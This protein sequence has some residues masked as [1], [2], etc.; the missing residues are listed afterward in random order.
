MLEPLLDEAEKRKLF[1]VCSV[2]PIECFYSP[3]EIRA[4]IKEGKHWIE[5]KTWVLRD[6]QIKIF[7]LER[8]ISQLRLELRD[9]HQEFVD[10]KI[11]EFQTNIQ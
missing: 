6:P 1:L 11:S 3:R 5:K 8:T 9:L 10:L 4:M 2:G 7:E